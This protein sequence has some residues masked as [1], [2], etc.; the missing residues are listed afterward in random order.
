VLLLIVTLFG[1][2]I[3]LN[4]AL[5]ATLWFRHP[6]PR[7]RVMLFDWVVRSSLHEHLRRLRLPGRRTAS[8]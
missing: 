2:W 7:L 4:A 3:A 5:F 8:P 1:C 6:H